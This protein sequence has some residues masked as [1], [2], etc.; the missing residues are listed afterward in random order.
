[1]SC[2]GHR[3]TVLLICIHLTHPSSDH[4]VGILPTCPWMDQ[5]QTPC[6]T[7]ECQH[8]NWV[9]LVE[10]RV[11][12][13]T[14]VRNSRMI[15]SKRAA[16]PT[17]L[18]PTALASEDGQTYGKHD[19]PQPTRILL[20]HFTPSIS[21]VCSPHPLNLSGTYDKMGITQITFTR[22][23]IGPHQAVLRPNLLEDGLQAR[24]LLLNAKRRQRGHSSRGRR[25]LCVVLGDMTYKSGFSPIGST[26]KLRLRRLY[27][28]FLLRGPIDYALTAPQVW[29]QKHSFF[30]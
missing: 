19:A 17:G 22:S 8:A 5:V 24:E 2:L 13:A 25:F 30:A 28:V 7:G 29:F 16:G 12:R 20:L 3:C 4:H 6:F 18:G 1:M 14:A 11:I 21:R 26:L 10:W 9:A 15:Q 23:K 27:R